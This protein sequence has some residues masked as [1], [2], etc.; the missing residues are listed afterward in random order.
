MALIERVLL[1]RH[2]ATAPPMPDA[3]WGGEPRMHDDADR[4]AYPAVVAFWRYER[5]EAML[6]ERRRRRSEGAR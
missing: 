3:V 1:H 5:A 2:A 4:R 6:D